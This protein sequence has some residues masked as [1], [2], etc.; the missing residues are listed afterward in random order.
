MD[1]ILGNKNINYQNLVEQSSSDTG[2]VSL[3]VE[4]S[5]EKEFEI[6]R[7]NELKSSSIIIIFLIIYTA[8]YFFSSMCLFIANTQG[9][10]V[11]E[12]FEIA[13]HSLDFIGSF[14]FALVEG[15]SLLMSNIVVVGEL[16]F[17]LLVLNIGM[18]L[19]GSILFILSPAYWEI[20]SHWIEFSAQVFLTLTDLIFISVQFKKNK[21]S[22]LYKYRYYELIFVVVLLV[23]SVFKLFVFG[24][25]VN[26][27][28]DPEQLAHFFEF[29]GE[30]ANSMFA[31]LFLTAYYSDIGLKIDTLTRSF[32][33]K[34]NQ[35]KK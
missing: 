7:Y 14:I 28:I 13:F 30:M 35:I 15:I 3:E 24:D 20:T 27:G 26:F 34:S 5:F 1:D 9:P 23:S 17:Y 12:G 6:V 29:S 25:A 18:T 33:N 16:R 8:I 19:T 10:E 31:L 21:E 2:M 4:M 22:I 11:I 32:I